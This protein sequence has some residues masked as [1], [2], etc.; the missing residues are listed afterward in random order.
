VTV[1]Q[2]PVRASGRT[3]SV[4]VLATASTTALL[5]VG[6]RDLDPMV[7]VGLVAIAFASWAI[8]VRRADHAGRAAGGILA[9]T[10]GALLVLAV[11]VPPQGSDDAWG[12]A[13]YGREVSAH[14]ASPYTHVPA[15]F[16]H[17]PI[18]PRMG[19]GHR[20][21]RSP[22]GPAF[23]GA[24]AVG[25]AIAGDSPLATRLVFQGGAALAVVAALVLL[26]RRTRSLGAIAWVGLNPLVIVSV[27]ND[28]HND[29]LVALAILGGVLLATDRRHVLAGVVLGL[30]ALV[31]L[32]ALLGMLG[33]GIWV[34][35]RRGARAARALCATTAAVVVLGYAVVGPSALVAIS[36]SAGVVSRASVW[37]PVRDWLIMHGPP[38]AAS[39]LPAIAVVAVVALALLLAFGSARAR[40]AAGSAGGALAAFPFAGAYVLPWYAA[41]GLPALALRRSAPLAWLAALEGAFLLAVY[42]MPDHASAADNGL[43]LHRLLSDVVPVAVLAAAVALGIAMVARRTPYAGRSRLRASALSRS[44]FRRGPSSS[45]LSSAA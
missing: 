11:L 23:T 18:L 16:P 41:W 32:P 7:A 24:S 21:T 36:D 6:R 44:T 42:Q 12:Y 45:S 30:A 35:R 34:W 2:T 28:G 27:V 39:P 8:V 5:V 13:V 29:A 3:L 26:W 19:S 40:D 17:D 4:A 22:Y 31:K 14:G 25:T 43:V 10:I 38:G 15:S 20:H 9:A 1:D 33:V 37:S